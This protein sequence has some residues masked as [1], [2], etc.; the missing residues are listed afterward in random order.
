MKT[1]LMNTQRKKRIHFLTR[2]RIQS[3][4]SIYLTKAKKIIT[5]NF[6][7]VIVTVQICQSTNY[8]QFMFYG[9]EEIRNIVNIYL[10]KSKKNIKLWIAKNGSIVNKSDPVVQICCKYQDLIEL[11]GII[12]GIIARGSSIATNSWLLLNATRRRIIFMGDRQDYFINHAFD[13]CAAAAGG[14]DCFTTQRHVA[15]LVKNK[16]KTVGTMPHSILAY[17]HGD[18]IKAGDLYLKSFP[19]QKLILLVDYHNDTVND[20]LKALSHFKE[21]LYAIRVDTPANLLDKSLQNNKRKVSLSEY[22]GSAKLIKKIR[23][24]LD[25]NNGNHVK[26]IV[27]SGI[28]YKKVVRFEKLNVPVDYYGV[29]KAILDI[30]LNFSANITM[31][32]DKAE[33]KTGKKYIE[34]KTLIR[35][36]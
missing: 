31:V 21:K 25:K 36:L 4:T 10:R 29:G 18:V 17:C 6:S 32:N 35:V 5:E 8:N 33:A 2:K 30:C 34:N 11:E 1:L 23:T 24:S 15:K 12:N 22:G 7:N 28:D 20:S 14:I 13:G 3:S 16:I 26:I 19:N 9:A 27:T